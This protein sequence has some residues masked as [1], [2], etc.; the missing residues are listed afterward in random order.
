[1]KR[2]CFLI[3]TLTILLSGQD[4]AYVDSLEQEIKKNDG[5]DKVEA[6]IHLGNY[7]NRYSPDKAV[8]T[9]RQG[10]RVSKQNENYSLGSLYR[11]MNFA[12]STMTN[13]DSSYYYI[14]KAEEFYRAEKD[15]AG[16][17]M[18]INNLGIYYTNIYDEENALV[19][20]NELKTL[21]IKKGLKNYE[22]TAY[23]NIGL[24]DMNRSDY[25]AALEKFLK[26]LEIDKDTGNEYRMVNTYVSLGALFINTNNYTKSADYF[27]KAR[28]IAEEQND[29]YHLWYI[30]YNLGYLYESKEEYS[31][32]IKYIDKSIEVGNKRKDF[33]SLAYSHL[34]KADVY[35]KQE[36]VEV[37][38]QFIREAEKLSKKI[39]SKDID[40]YIED[41]KADLAVKKGDYQE[42]LGHHYR[43]ITL[44]SDISY[45]N[46]LKFFHKIRYGKIIANL[47]NADKG[48]EIIKDALKTYNEP[49]LFQ[50]KID[51]YEDLYKIYKNERNYKEAF[52][53]LKIYA[54][55]SDSLKV[56]QRKSNMEELELIHQIKQQKNE[57]ELLKK[58][59]HMNN[60]KIKFQKTLLSVSILIT[61]VVI[62]LILII[63]KSLLNNKRNNKKLKYQNKLIKRNKEELEKS[64]AAKDRLYAIIEDDL[65]NAHANL[66]SFINILNRTIDNLDKEFIHKL[67]S[68]LERINNNS[69]SLLNSLTE[70]GRIQTRKTDFS[71]MTFNLK[72]MVHDVMLLFKK[73]I[74][75]KNI[76]IDNQLPNNA[77]VFCDKD[78]IETVVRN[79]LSNAIKYTEMNGKILV[80]GKFQ[81]K[82]L[83]MIIAD[84]GIGISPE[85]QKKLFHIEE[86]ITTK[87][88]K[89][90]KGHGL[91]LIISKELV[92]MNKGDISLKSQVGKGTELIVKLPAAQ[93]DLY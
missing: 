30:Y 86:T 18:A 10:I 35:I 2:I 42:A 69:L 51:G 89:G 56:L 21:A 5:K 37:A 48:I 59:Q 19:T 87:G 11:I 4:Q 74:Q 43:A 12:H 71:P 39:N 83:K 60:A 22:A 27:F 31:E 84:D 88:T 63:I 36:K 17:C 3:I 1:M 81:E 38:N 68:E 65:Y 50:T 33:L 90:E 70:W 85:R 45:P 75:A 23:V 61:L 67:T 58:E 16:I 26:A 92:K 72:V 34:L 80:S 73:N 47:K 13:Y 62:F 55:L 77:E 40:S 28:E 76:N 9:G 91:G 8:K 24:M 25:N 57:T 41:T 29:F 49:E 32:A 44:L 93:F 78:M 66:A 15:T 14:K 7:Y 46:E 54:N 52:N 20:Y 79:L 53:N 6:L 64:I 82:F